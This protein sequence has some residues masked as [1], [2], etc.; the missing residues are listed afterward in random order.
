MA[1]SATVF[2]LLDEY[3]KTQHSDKSPLSDL[4][5]RVDFPSSALHVELHLVSSDP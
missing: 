4:S 1:S 2:C 5:D 3:L